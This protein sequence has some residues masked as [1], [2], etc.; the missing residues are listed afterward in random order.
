MENY[1]SKRLL[2]F[3]RGGAVYPEEHSEDVAVWARDLAAPKDA[4]RG[5]I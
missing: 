2:W 4:G 5:A 3:G 1:K